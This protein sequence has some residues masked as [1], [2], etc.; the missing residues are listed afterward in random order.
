LGRE[1]LGKYLWQNGLLERGQRNDAI[2]RVEHHLWFGDR[3]GDSA[4]I[5]IANDQE[6]E[7]L[8]FEWLQKKHNGVCRHTSKAN[9]QERATVH[10]E[11]GQVL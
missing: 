6:L 5:R 2:P 4:A 7:A 10:Q 1:Q 8:I 9:C 3:E 11:I